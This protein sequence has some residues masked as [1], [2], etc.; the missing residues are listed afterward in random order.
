MMIGKIEGTRR[1]GWQRIGCL[2]NIA[3]SMD[4]DQGKLQ[5]I[6]EDRGAWH[7]TVHEV[8]VRIQLSN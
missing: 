1:K 5:E 2:D 3:D 6:M 4:M 7:A 8:T